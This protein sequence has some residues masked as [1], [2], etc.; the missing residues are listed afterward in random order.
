E[1]GIEVVYYELLSKK[2]VDQTVNFVIFI[3]D[4]GFN[5]FDLDYYTSEGYPDWREERALEELSKRIEAMHE[6]FPN[7]KIFIIDTINFDVEDL[8]SEGIIIPDDDQRRD[9]D[10]DQ[11]RDEEL[12]QL[13]RTQLERKRK[14]LGKIR[15]QYFQTDYCVPKKFHLTVPESGQR[16][17]AE[18]I[19]GIMKNLSKT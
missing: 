18:R 17:L 8:L 3:I 16:E 7:A 11:R 4:H 12:L 19:I 1:Q 13:H 6:E 5:D 14:V 15:R 10:D 9:I 2:K